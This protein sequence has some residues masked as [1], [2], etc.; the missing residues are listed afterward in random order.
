M[1]IL[2]VA[3]GLQETCGV[4]NFVVETARAQQTLEHKVVIVTTM[5]CGYPVSDLDVRLMPDPTTVDFAPDVVHLHSTWNRYVHAMARWSRER[6]I[7]YV[8][9]PHGALTPW[10]LRYKW[11]K[12]WP[13]LLLYQYSD[14]RHAAAFHV[15]VAEEEADVRRLRL[16]Q[17]VC[18]APLGVH[19]PTATII[20]TPFHDVLSLGRIHPKKNLE[21][22]L[23][24]WSLLSPETRRGW[25]IIIAGP[26]D[27]GH[28]A[29]LAQHATKLGLTTRDLT[30]EVAFGKKQ[31][32]GGEE[33]PAEVFREKLADCT[34]DV[35]F[36]G[37]VYSGAKDFLYQNSRLFALP[38][39]SEN[40]GVVV[41]E[42][43][44]AGTPVI[45]STGTP[46]Q[47]L[48]QN[49]CGWWVDCSPATLADTLT[50]AMSL[51]PNAYTQMQ[52]DAR[53][54]VRQNYSWQTTAQKLLELYQNTL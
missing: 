4:S 19:V 31:I 50:Q 35:V 44:A 17:P 54:F 36:T 10:A 18:T 6:N 40:F 5:T 30:T 41:L 52:D 45:A 25:R 3:A 46:W 24:A 15:T 8:I 12:K 22:L 13:A 27:V 47:A 16:R 32:L 33:V 11:W 49:H 48:P 42:A 34:A 2:H 39:H 21:A 29:V 14:F 53:Q 51:S 28:Q 37:A 7:P 26:D 38:S 20:D 23:D 1:K 43:L 9:S